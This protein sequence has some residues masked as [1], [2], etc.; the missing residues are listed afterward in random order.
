VEFLTEQFSPFCYFTSLRYRY[1]PIVLQATW[2]LSPKSFI[3][4][5]YDNKADVHKVF[6]TS[7]KFIIV[8]ISGNLL[9]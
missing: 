8:L 9:V 4:S 3:D 1:S 7:L 2:Y 5:K 6:S